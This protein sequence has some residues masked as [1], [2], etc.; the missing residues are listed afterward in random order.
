MA[1]SKL[2]Y[3]NM[4]LGSNELTA[5][6]HGAEK[7]WRV[8]F[9]PHIRRRPFMLY[10]PTARDF[11]V[12]GFATIHPISAIHDLNCGQAGELTIEMPVDAYGEWT[13]VTPNTIILAPTKWRGEYKPQAFRVYRIVKAMDESGRKTLTVYARHVFYDMMYSVLLNEAFSAQTPTLAIKHIF[14]HQFGFSGTDGDVLNPYFYHLASDAWYSRDGGSTVENFESETDGQNR[15]FEFQSTSLVD[16]LIGGSGSI[17]DIYGLELYADNFYFSLFTHENNVLRGNVRE[18]AFDIRYS[19]DMINVSEDVD[20]T[21]AFTH[22]FA[23]DNAG[24]VWG[25]SAPE[26]IYGPFARPKQVKFSYR[27]PLDYTAALGRLSADGKKYWDDNRDVTRTYTAKY[28]PLHLDQSRD[29]LGQLDGRE[30]GDTGIVRND[31][32]GIVSTGQRIISKRVDLLRDITLD[33]K[34]GNAPATITKQG[35]W[36]NTARSTPP[37]AVE[38]QIEAMQSS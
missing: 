8:P 11:T 37:S 26:E 30:V 13:Q 20:Y 23:F 24:L 25:I 15:Y 9:E 32:L 18:N 35:A 7:I 29:F 16:A 3:Q 5:V 10:E 22:L 4:Y 6:Y 12:N 33:I 36:S 17:A 1:S 27:D 34:L 19:F 2:Y 21:N 38:K 31:S 28:A 14:E